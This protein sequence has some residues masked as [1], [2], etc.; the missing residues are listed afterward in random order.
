MKAFAGLYAALGRTTST[1]DKLAAMQEYFKAAAPADAAWAVYFLSGHKPRQVVPSRKLLA[2]AAE[3]ARIPEWLAGESLD[4][5]GDLAEAVTL[6]LP[7]NNVSDPRPLHEWVEQRLLPLRE[8][9]EA[10][11]R[12][13]LES[14]WHALDDAQR[15]VWNKLI[16]GSL[17]IGVSQQSVMRALAQ[18]SGLDI[19]TIA[20]RMMGQWQ[21]SAAFFEQLIHPDDA[22]VGQSHPYPFF[23]CYALDQPPEQLGDIEA[24]AAEW[25]WDG[26]RAQLIKRN[27]EIFLW[28]RGEE[29]IGERFPEIVSAATQ[30]D[31]DFVIDGEILSWANGQ[32]LPFGR[33]QRR[34]GRKKLTPALLKE[35]PAVLMSYDLLE[36]SGADL[37]AEPFAKRRAALENLLAGFNDNIILSPLIEARD[38]DE[39]AALR[40][41]SREFQV[42]GFVLKEK[43]SQYG[44]G[45]RRGAWWK[46]KVDP[47]T[48]DAVL[49]YAQSGHG[50]RASLYTDYTFGI[51]RDGALVPFAKAYS[52]LSDDEIREV[53]R[54]IRANTVERFGPVRAVKPELVFE[55]AFEAIQRSTRHKSGIAVRFPRMLR[56][57]RDKTPIDADSL[58][59]IE[60]ML[61]S[62]SDAIQTTG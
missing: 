26:I 31:H 37:R 54:Y 8:M 32:V 7:P 43:Q 50:R 4:A 41:R 3:T 33:L 20:H 12:A 13:A 27:G 25:K 14:A 22:S 23:L 9:P 17:R 36:L 51:W 16:A 10:H 30:L 21:P 44:A 35:I 59:T 1:N 15:L 11:Q 53:D 49:I 62:Q 60:A 19:K 5:V 46:W 18:V 29:L 28:S 55:L 57:R 6:L 52:G 56:W 48:I 2:W 34:I 24:W 45:R 61:A 58:T 38:W 40:Q 39:L 42:E 47:Y